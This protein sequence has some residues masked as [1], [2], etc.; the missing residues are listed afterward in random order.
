[1]SQEGVVMRCGLCHREDFTFSV[2]SY[3][4]WLGG[5]RE[6][7]RLPSGNC[8]DYVGQI[9]Q[10]LGSSRPPSLVNL[11][12]KLPH[13]TRQTPTNPTSLSLLSIDAYVCVV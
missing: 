4:I 7:L 2:D 11:L 12:A 13:S 3:D 6:D 1:M 8:E 9:Y 10:S 5:R